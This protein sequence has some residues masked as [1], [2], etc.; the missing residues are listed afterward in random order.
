M[1]D[2]KTTV[3]EWT[4]PEDQASSGTWGSKLNTTLEAID[5]EVKAREDEITATETVANAA[6][7]K[8][9]GTMSGEITVLTTRQTRV[10][11]GNLSGTETLDFN[12]ANAWTGTV[13]GTCTIALSNVDSGTYIV[14]GV[15]KITNGAAFVVTWPAVFKWEDG[16]A[17]TLTTSGVDYI[18]F[19]S[20]DGGTTFGAKAVLDVK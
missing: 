20:L 5:T 8:A 6:L 13:T 1:A 2:G 18:A 4:T 16:A 7:P 3:Y 12:A 9:G 17:P 10:D 19:V 11:L 15:L 14:G